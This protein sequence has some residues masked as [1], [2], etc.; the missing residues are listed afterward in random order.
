MQALH[1]QIHE[2]A[3]IDSTNRWLADQARAGAP[4]GTVAWAWHQSAGRGR[5]GRD[6]ESEPGASLLLSVL[7]RPT[8]A[9]EARHLAVASVALAAREG[10]VRLSG[11]RPD[12][13]WPN[14]LLVD[15]AKLGGV[16]G[17]FIPSDD[18]PDGLVIGI[19]INLISSPVEGSVSVRELS[20]VTLDP[21]AVADVLLEGL[22]RR[23]HLLDTPEGLREVA[24]EFRRS[25]STL[26]RDVTV[27]RFDDIFQA[28][29]IDVD[30]GGRLV[31]DR[32]G[33]QV[34]VD[35]GDV[36]HVRRSS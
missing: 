33:A 5:L 23:R 16:L 13:K 35:V 14:D 12:L 10:L 15:D 7:L 17:E 22:E 2:F 31:L 1:W 11:V 18:G 28:R 30:D 32:E 29:A 19:G 9:P 8:L 27:E 25:L 20:G 6:W 34:V 24:D 4:E 3:E 21:P 36:V 26:G